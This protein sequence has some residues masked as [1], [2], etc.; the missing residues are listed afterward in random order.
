L[1]V[2]NEIKFKLIIKSL[3]ATELTV[4]RLF[5]DIS[6]A[7]VETEPRLF[8]VVSWCKMHWRTDEAGKTYTHS[9]VIEGSEYT[10]Q[11]NL[12]KKHKT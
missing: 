10:T 11:H 6:K 5:A 7:G 1:L 9:G 8:E 4:S 2:T 3:T 12:I